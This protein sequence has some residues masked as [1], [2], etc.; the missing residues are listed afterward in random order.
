MGIGQKKPY[1]LSSGEVN[2]LFLLP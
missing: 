1:R 2:Q